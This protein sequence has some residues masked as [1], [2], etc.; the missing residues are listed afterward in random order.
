MGARGMRFRCAAFG[1]GGCAGDRPRRRRRA[2]GEAALT[3]DQVLDNMEA[4][5]KT[6]KTFK[7]DVA[8]LRQ[9]TGLDDSHFTGTIQFKSPRLLKLDLKNTETGAETISYVGK[10]FGWIYRPQRKAGGA[11]PARRH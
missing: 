7:A 11:R 9:A 4:V 6:I 2:T 10:K 5:R 3:V 8:K 1:A